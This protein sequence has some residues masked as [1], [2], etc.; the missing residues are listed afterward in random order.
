MSTKSGFQGPEEAPLLRVT[1]LTKD[2]GPVRAVDGLSFEVRRGEIV[3]LLG[4]N[5]AGKS[6]AMRVLT[7]YQVPT[8]G[9]IRLA[10]RDVFLDGPMAKR[11]LGYLP[12]NPPL[13]GEMRVR[14]Y[15]S[16]TGRLKGLGARELPGALGRVKAQMSLEA[17]WARPISQLS[18]GFRPRTGSSSPSGAST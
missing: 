15:L 16:L 12:E 3:G 13:Y 7:G 1:S 6:T 4:P 17:V 10:G 11:A 9:S 2:Y 14:D 5:G 18:R 8:S